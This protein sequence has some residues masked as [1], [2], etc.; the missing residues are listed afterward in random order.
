MGQ[1]KRNTAE[2]RKEAMKVQYFAKLNNCQSSPRKMRLIADMIRGM[3]AE[4]A[5]G[6]LKYAPQEASVKMYKLLLSAISNWQTKNEGVR[7]EDASLYVKEVMVDGGRILKRMHPRAKGMGNRIL[8]RSNHVTL[9][10]GSK[11]AEAVNTENAET[12]IDNK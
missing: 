3:K 10:L 11:T 5:L 6:V 1:R 9:Y 8:K 4:Q 7:M 12:G 2:A